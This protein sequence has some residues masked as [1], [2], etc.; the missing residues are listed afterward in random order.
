MGSP[1]TEKGRWEGEVQHVVT[2]AEPF[3]ISSCEITQVQ[4]LACMSANPSVFSKDGRNPVEE[5][6]WDDCQRFA[7]AL[8][9]R[10]GVPVGAYRLPTESEWE[11]ACRAGTRTAYVCGNRADG[12]DQFAD[13]AENNN[14][15]T[16][17]VG[18]RRPNAYGL[19]DMHGNVW[20][21]CDDKFRPYEPVPD[22]PPG[23]YDY[24]EWR[25][26]RGG[27]WHEPAANCRSAN[28]ARLPPL[29][30]GNMLGFRLVRTVPAAPNGADAVPE[31]RT[32][33]TPGD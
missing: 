20:E 14:R 31:P 5:V 15:R 33:D 12:L 28:R 23:A 24:A 11:Y 10:E 27:N 13:Y 25:V 7:A 1:P 6:T 8:C 26:I 3:Y 16:S 2:L 29:S 19:Y 22:A 9:V 17:T 4:W 18:R 21:W 32:Q 30:K